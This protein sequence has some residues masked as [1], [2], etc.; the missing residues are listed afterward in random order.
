MQQV[1]KANKIMVKAKNPNH[2]T[3]YHRTFNH[4]VAQPNEEQLGAVSDLLAALTMDEIQA[5]NLTTTAEIV[6]SPKEV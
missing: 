3:A 1:F 4:F 5:L 2:P 6:A